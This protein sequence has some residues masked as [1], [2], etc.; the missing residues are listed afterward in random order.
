MGECKYYSMHLL[1]I[2]DLLS[3]KRTAGVTIQDGAINSLYAATSQE[4]L[5]L[6][7]KVCS[8]QLSD[9]ILC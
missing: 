3:T 6:G 7:G 4:A 8:S 1:A 2:Y 5:T 9:R